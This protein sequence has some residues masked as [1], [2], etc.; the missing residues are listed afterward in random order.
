MLHSVK[1]KLIAGMGVL[2]LVSFGLAAVLLIRQK[3]VELSSD[4][5]HSVKRFS[6]LTTPQIVELYERYLSQDSFVYFNRE[7]QKLFDKTDDIV[8]IGIASYPGTILYD[9]SEEGAEQYAGEPR[10][11]SDGFMLVRIQATYPSYSLS[12]GRVV[13]LKT[14]LEG[15]VV[16]LDEND[17][18]VQLIDPEDR[19]VDV[20]YPYGGQYALLF[21]PSYEVLD[22]RIQSMV[23][24]MVLLALFALLV[25]M[26]FAYFFSIG[27]TRPLKT[28]QTGALQ[29]GGGDFKVRVNVKSRDEV[30]VLA[31]T[32]NK[33][34]ED[35]EK[36][37][38][39]KLYKER[40]AKELEL[41]SQIQQDL[42]PQTVPKVPGLDLAAGLI[43]AT[44]VGGDVYD[45]ISVDEENYFGYVGDVTGHGVPAGLLV[46]VTN[47]LIHSYAHL[48]DP[49]E[50]LLQANTVLRKKTRANM[51]VTLV[52]WHWNATSQQLKVVSAGHEVALKYTSHPVKTEELQKGGI[53]LG[54]LPDI[55]AL[56]KAQTVTLEKGDCVVFYT[57]GVPETWRNE[58]EQY[59]MPEFK[60]VVTQS[61]DLPHAEAI[62]VALLAD[63]KQWSQGYEQKD[64]MTVMVL[65]KT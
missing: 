42:L 41:A 28:L 63:A 13:Y 65:K 16:A 20:V 10:L 34:A 22:T 56:L 17:Q 21:A 47:A 26:A 7:V 58:K 19:I 37:V 45:F 59:G 2:L 24:N 31:T 39:N 32:F 64:D 27:I 49:V 62:K 15:G 12:S 9:S 55:R 51:F 8:G 57:D 29:L 52:L 53:A 61:C 33:M 40:V 4:L 50:I 6:D 48:G 35:L 18:E 25:G 14:D 1:S 38:E 54:M 11:I 23:Q 46:S 60:R 36:S 43:P 5:Y 44:E 3:T 30:G